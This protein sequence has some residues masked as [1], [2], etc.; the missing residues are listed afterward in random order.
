MTHPIPRLPTFDWDTFSGPKEA[1]TPCLLTLPKARYTVSGRASIL[2]ALEMLNIGPGDKVLVPTYHCP[3]MIAPVVALGAQPIFYPIESNGAPDLQWIKQHHDT[4]IRGM[5]AAHFFGLPQPL[6]AIRHWCDQQGV[7]LIEDCAHSL[8][9]MS[10]DRAVGLWGDLA[11]ASLT[12]FLPVPEGG[13]LVNNL[14]TGPLPVLHKRTF[15]GQIKAAF[16][17]IHAGVTYGR[18]TG[19]GRLVNG[20]SQVRSLLKPMPNRPGLPPDGHHD[21]V[22]DDNVNIDL[23]QAH[24]E[25]TTTSRWVAQH[26]PRGR[27]VQRRRENY[28]FFT[29]TLSGLAGVR[30]LLPRLPDHC[31]PYVFALWV[32]QPDPGYAELRRLGFPVSRWDRLW[33]TVPAL[34]GDF[35]TT[36]AHHVLQL[37]CHQDLTSKE[38][39]HMAAS[40]KQIFVP[41]PAPS[42]ATTEIPLE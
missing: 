26:A 31:A 19:L 24:Q 12:K 23:P 18:L 4:N 8:F 14:A 27:I 22:A 30:P 21:D 40:L 5:L 37:A 35:G 39:N 2:L 29:Q 38:L 25:L 9:G 7:R 36:W 1:S 41:L 28:T 42:S 13:C 3:T 10:G 20:A 33:P 17:I 11:I 6:A 34:E 16:D 32:D 15:N